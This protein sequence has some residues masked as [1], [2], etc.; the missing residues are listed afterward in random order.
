[1]RDRTPDDVESTWTLPNLQ[2]L[3]HSRAEQ[4]A[5]AGCR[6]NLHHVC[7]QLPGRVDL[8][9]R[10][11]TVPRLAQAAR[12]AISSGPRCARGSTRWSAAT[13]N[14]PVPPTAAPAPGAPGVNTVRNAVAGDREQHRTRTCRTV[15]P[16]PAS[17]PTRPPYTRV[18]DAHTGTYASRI[19]MSSRTDGDAKLVPTFDLGQCSSQVAQGAPTR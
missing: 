18:T 11:G 8:A 12:R 15:S 2:N 16:R 7:D 17:A 13:V 10:P 14:R 1:M 9:D 3:R 5:A 4:I 19:S 6:Y